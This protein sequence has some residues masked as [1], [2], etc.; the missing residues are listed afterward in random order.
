MWWCHFFG[1]LNAFCQILLHWNN[2]TN[3]F[4]HFLIPPYLFVLDRIKEPPKGFILNIFDMFFITSHFFIRLIRYVHI[5]FQHTMT[6]SS[7]RNTL[8]S[9]ISVF[10][11]L[12]QFSLYLVI[13]IP[14]YTM[15]I[16][17][18]GSTSFYRLTTTICSTFIDPFPPSPVIPVRYS[19]FQ[20]D[21][22]TLN[23]TSSTFDKLLSYA[24]TAR[25]AGTDAISF[26][27]DSFDIA[28]GNCASRT[29]TFNRSDFISPIKQSQIQHITGAGGSVPVKGV[30]DVEYFVTDDNGDR[31]SLIVSDALYVPGLPFRLLA[32]NQLSK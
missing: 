16:L 31:H 28:M 10:S 17:H 1:I 20:Q 29:M 21:G 8:S 26:D 32:V 25:I 2:F 18:L 27:S 22:I 4:L 23:N 3:E 7:F 15:H 5:I 19:I 13:R 6:T 14:L 9:A 30:G 12:L 24:L 11:F